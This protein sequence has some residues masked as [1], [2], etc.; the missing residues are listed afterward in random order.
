MAGPVGAQVAN[1][2]NFGMLYSSSLGACHDHW[3]VRPAVVAVV[4][5]KAR[6]ARST[7]L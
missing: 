5:E 2:S 7:L 1:Q 6:F 3:Y 4:R